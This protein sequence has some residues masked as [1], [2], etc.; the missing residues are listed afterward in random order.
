MINLWLVITKLKNFTPY[1]WLNS[2]PTQPK[3]LLGRWTIDY[4]ENKINKKID[5]SNEDHCGTCNNNKNIYINNIDSNNIN[6]KK[7][8]FFETM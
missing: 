4:C 2:R 7:L 3:I 1:I 5:F 8:I 6:F